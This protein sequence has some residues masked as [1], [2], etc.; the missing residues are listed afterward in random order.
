[1]KLWRICR[2]DFSGLDGEG[3]RLY[4]GRWNSEGL[5]VV[6]LSTSLPL[7]VLEYLVHL[8]VKTAPADLVRIE[9]DLPDTTTRDQVRI[10]DLPADWNTTS[11]HPSCVDAGDGWVRGGRACLLYVPSAV[12]PTDLNVLMNPA[13]VEAGMA[14]AI[15]EPFVLDRRLLE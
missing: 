8:D 7:A 9:V 4:G 11:D 14:T 10:E 1:M 6:Y 5:A 12:V 2:R 13:H 15:A 3:A